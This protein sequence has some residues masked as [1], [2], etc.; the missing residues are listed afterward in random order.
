M[1]FGGNWF[2]TSKLLKW[3]S[4]T[5]LSLSWASSPRATSN[6]SQCDDKS[7]DNTQ[8]VHEQR[9]WLVPCHR[10]MERA[11]I[12]RDKARWTE[13]C[14]L[15]RVW[16]ISWS[17]R[18]ACQCVDVY[19]LN[20]SGIIS[21]FWRIIQFRSLSHGAHPVNTCIHPL[22][23]RASTVPQTIASPGIPLPLLW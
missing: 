4:H 15:Y 6:W 18:P 3:T 22:P 19:N 11:M 2:L 13:F 16:R 21:L 14:G 12:R 7:K 9:T 10:M 17:W 5:S 8:S 23:S 1:N 20:T